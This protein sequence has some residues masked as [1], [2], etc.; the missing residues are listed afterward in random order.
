[1]K[2]IIL[3]WCFCF[4]KISFLQAQTEAKG[5]KSVGL[6]HILAA[7][8]GWS[9]FNQS[10]QMVSSPSQWML[11]CHTRI[12]MIPITQA[13]VGY[14]HTLPEKRSWGL[15]F[16]QNGMGDFRQREYVAAYAHSVGPHFSL[17]LQCQYVALSYTDRYYGVSRGGSF[18]LSASCQPLPAWNCC[19]LWV[20]PFLFHYRFQREAPALPSQL[21]FSA[22]YHWTSQL[23]SYLECTKAAEFPFSAAFGLEREW[24]SVVFRCAAS[25]P[26]FQFSSGLG[27]RCGRLYWDVACR[28][29]PDLGMELAFS[30]QH[31]T[32]KL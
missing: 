11:Q 15:G 19:F 29:H 28:Y 27:M 14:L 10:S 30:I 18:S 22:I 6:C 26:E 9:L 4:V 16:N 31:Q 7:E 32:G 8:D 20:N 17:A 2:K 5:A 21:C 12:G 3:L 25:L 13:A 23:R 1:M 24:N